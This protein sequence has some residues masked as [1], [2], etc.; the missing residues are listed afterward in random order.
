[1]WTVS[2]SEL[3]FFLVPETKDVSNGMFLLTKMVVSVL[4]SN[5]VS[6]SLFINLKNSGPVNKHDSS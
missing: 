4:N 2:C 1:M 5:K 3:G 6:L